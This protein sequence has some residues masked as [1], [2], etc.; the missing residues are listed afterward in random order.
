MRQDAAV[1]LDWYDDP[2]SPEDSNLIKLV[3]HRASFSAGRNID[4]FESY[5]PKLIAGPHNSQD[6]RR[7]LLDFTRHTPRD[8]VTLLNYV[9][10]FA[11]SSDMLSEDNILSATR[12]YSV[13]YFV[14]EIKDELHGYL[15]PEEIDRTI[16]LFSSLGKRE[17]TYG[18]IVACAEGF[19]PSL[20]LDM[21]EV[22]GHLF[23][24]SA[25]GS[26]ERSGG[27]TYFTVKYRN[28]N[29]VLNLSHKLILHR[30]MWKALNLG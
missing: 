11:G 12:S 4:I 18:Q 17:F 28:R 9:Q 21:R 10:K 22:L 25:L 20:G 24:C 13:N 8:F 23:E 14:P 5:F 29:A 6:V 26:L 1:H 15:T 2:S 30:G 7:F 27:H 19:V 3:N 16:S